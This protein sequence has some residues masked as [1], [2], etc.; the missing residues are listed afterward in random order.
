MHSPDS[1]KMGRARPEIAPDL[2]S[3]LVRPY[4]LFYQVAGDLVQIVRI[5]HGNRDLKRIMQQEGED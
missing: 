2:R 3:T 1:Q 4:V 5:L